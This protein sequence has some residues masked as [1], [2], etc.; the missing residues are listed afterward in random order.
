MNVLKR[1]GGVLPRCRVQFG[2]TPTLKLKMVQ[3]VADMPK[4]VLYLS[5]IR[6]LCSI[7]PVKLS[8]CLA[9]G[10]FNAKAT[11]DHRLAALL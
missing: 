11:R 4:R 7:F 3:M 9:F 2:A 10:Y 6:I 1:F 5:L 8:V